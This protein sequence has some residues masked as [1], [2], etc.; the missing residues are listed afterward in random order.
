M[1]KTSDARM[2]LPTSLGYGDVV[3]NLSRIINLPLGLKNG[4]VTLLNDL[5][6]DKLHEPYRCK[7]INGFADIKRVVNDNNGCL[8]ISGSGSTMLVI[9]KDDFNLDTNFLVKDVSVCDGI[10]INS[11]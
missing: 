11:D 2:V 10:I 5:F 7:L 4:D 1:V 3:W 6:V 8:I 9:Y